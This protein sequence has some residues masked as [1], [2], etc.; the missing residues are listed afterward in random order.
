MPDIVTLRLA[1]KYTDQKVSEAVGEGGSGDVVGPASST[2]GHLAVFSG[3]TGKLL[4]DRGVS[5]TDF[6]TAAQ[7]AKAD[8]AVQPDDLAAVAFTGSYNDLTD[9]PSTPSVDLAALLAVSGAVVKLV[10]RD[11]N[12]RWELPDGTVPTL[13]NR[14]ASIIWEGTSAQIPAQGAGDAEFREGDVAL[15]RAESL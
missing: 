7:G 14:A 11:S 4:E 15:V 2:D 3:A 13:T 9:T 12:S 6:A 8:T 5:P 10:Y 1:Q